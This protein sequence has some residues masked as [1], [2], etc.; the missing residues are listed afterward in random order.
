MLS[1]C[2]SWPLSRTRKLGMTWLDGKRAEFSEGKMTLASF[3]FHFI[4]FI[5]KKFYSSIVAL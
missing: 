4:L 2:A 1:G 3:L 5:F